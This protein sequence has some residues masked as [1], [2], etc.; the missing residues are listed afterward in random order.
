M[1]LEQMR[2]SGWIPCRFAELQWSAV[3]KKMRLVLIVPG[4][5]S[6][7]YPQIE[8]PFSADG[9]PYEAIAAAADLQI[10]SENARVVVVKLDHL[11]PLSPESL[12]FN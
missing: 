5:H 6:G 1:N 9:S 7:S 12:H 2:E 4:L 10:I 11:P 3:D 8:L